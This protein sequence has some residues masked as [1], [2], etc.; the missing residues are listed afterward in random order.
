MGL[1]IVTNPV[2]EPAS[3]KILWNLLSKKDSRRISSKTI[4]SDKMDKEGLAVLK[5]KIASKGRNIKIK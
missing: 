5:R 1:A 4:M 3:Q 2:L